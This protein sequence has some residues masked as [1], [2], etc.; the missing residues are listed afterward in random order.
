MKNEKMHSA[1]N[2]QVNAEI[3]SAYLY[4]SMAAYFEANNLKGFANWMKVQAEEELGH[5]MK[6]YKFISAQLF[7]DYKDNTFNFDPLFS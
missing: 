4:L 6:F 2:K 3:Y 1:L 7:F 5:A